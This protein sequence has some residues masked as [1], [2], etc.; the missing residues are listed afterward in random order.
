MATASVE[1]REGWDMRMADGL[2]WGEA[3]VGRLEGAVDDPEWGLAA[4]GMVGRRAVK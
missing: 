1:R 2:L 3:A 4:H